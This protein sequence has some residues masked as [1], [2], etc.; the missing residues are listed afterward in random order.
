M[1]SIVAAAVS[2]G[3]A[4]VGEGEGTWVARAVGVAAGGRNNRAFAAALTSM[5][6]VSGVG[7]SVGS[8]VASGAR[9]RT[10]AG[11]R[12]RDVWRRA[13]R[14]CAG[15]G[16]RLVAAAWAFL[17]RWPGR[18]GRRAGRAGRWV[19]VVGAL[20]LGVGAACL[21]P[22]VGAACLRLGVGCGVA[23]GAGC[24]AG[25][26]APTWV[27][28]V[29]SATGGFAGRVGSTRTTAVGLGR[30]VVFGQRRLGEAGSPTPTI[31]TATSA[32]R[33]QHA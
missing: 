29:A 2:G 9:G 4:G 24:L 8:R 15:F 16:A 10:R 33:I 7:S 13:W 18:G 20:V 14:G 26:G 11:A 17:D 28:G 21:R 31:S 3:N 32:L 12:R 1:V 25:A 6:T 22:G 5:I 19:G 23:F 30:L 27:V